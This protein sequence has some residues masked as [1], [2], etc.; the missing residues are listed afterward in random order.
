M[1]LLSKLVSRKPA[2]APVAAF[3]LE[4]PAA[5]KVR[6]AKKVAAK[7]APAG[8]ASK[9]AAV[10]A[11]FPL[12]A[13]LSNARRLLLS[14]Q[15][16]FATLQ[17]KDVPPTGFKHYV[18]RRVEPGLVQALQGRGAVVRVYVHE[19]AMRMP[20]VRFGLVLDGY[21]AWGFSK[22]KSGMTVLFGGC[23]T[24]SA[25]IVQTL[26]FS[27]GKLIAI[28]EH[29]LPSLGDGLF[30]SH[31]GIML[32]KCRVAYPSA[33]FVQAAPLSDWEE[34]GIEY[35]GQAALRRIGY[36]KITEK[37]AS[38]Q[39]NALPIAVTLLA[40]VGAIGVAYAGWAKYN[41][42]AA[43]YAIAIDDPLIRQHGGVDTTGLDRSN[44]R[45]AYMELPRRQHA[46]VAVATQVA[47]GV[48]SIPATKIVD[49][50][51]PAPATNQGAA[52]VGFE[53]GPAADEARKV[54]SPDR[55][56]DFRATISAPKA[57]NMTGLGQGQDLLEQLSKQTGMSLRL[58]HQGL[59]EEA[60]KRLYTIEGFVH[61]DIAGNSKKDQ[62]Q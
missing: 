58:A 22:A 46:L 3:D 57:G 7:K 39:S 20:K 8:P 12:S 48:A 55:A 60:N 15:S 32:E 38:S 6:P 52:A 27:A 17:D 10:V 16:V 9:Q 18:D 30:K 4:E 29:M 31:L 41:T 62:A 23:E 25:V 34:Q 51:V 37:K 2:G 1:N 33:R 11:E 54:L 42:A 47:K 61:A 44:A 21:L 28:D 49:L 45:R 53:A 5:V 24:A 26:V 43:N 19:A 13:E 40:G 50:T 36:N 14:G 59:R 56:P 35:V